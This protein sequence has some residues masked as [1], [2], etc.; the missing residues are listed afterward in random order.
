MEHFEHRHRHRL[1]V[2][3]LSWIRQF[4]SGEEDQNS[5]SLEDYRSP[6][7]WHLAGTPVKSKLLM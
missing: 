5:R 7:D 1:L 3:M 6:G 4:L 2:P